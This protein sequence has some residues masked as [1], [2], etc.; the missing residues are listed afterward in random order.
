MKIVLSAAL[1]LTCSLTFAQPQ[2]ISQATIST[3][4]TVIA[5]ET[6]DVQNIQGSGGGPGGGNQFFRNFGDGETKST[7]YIK[8]SLVKTVMKNDM[9][10]TTIIRNNNSKLTTT[11]LEIMGNKTGFYISDDEQAIMKLK[12]DSM[13]QSRR[14]N[15]STKPRPTPAPPTAPEITYTNDS[16]KI[17]GYDCKKALIVN[18]RL[19]GIKDTVAVWYTPELKLKSVSSTGGTSSFGGF[20]NFGNFTSLNGLD[21]IDGFVMQYEMNMRRG[22]KMIVE[23]NKI[24]VKK[25]ISA[26]EFDIP[27]DFDVK[28]MKEFQSMMQG[29][30]QGG[31]MPFRMDK[32]GQ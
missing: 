20:G 21:K 1:L 3:T 11:L 27:K 10:R 8:D 32:P 28:P 30:M 16:K 17:A 14:N 7:T 29:A 25:D 24:D 18:T 19:L 6:E 2:V 4:T 31:N 26:K 22:R 12:M 9:G 23:V 15:D 13:M 5:P